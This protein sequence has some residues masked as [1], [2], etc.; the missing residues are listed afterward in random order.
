MFVTLDDFLNSNHADNPNEGQLIMNPDTHQV[1]YK[2]NSATRKVTNF[3][4]WLEAYLNY[5]KLMIKA[6]GIMA[7]HAMSDYI[8][9]IHKNDARF[10]WYAVDNFDVQHRQWLSGKTINMLNVDPIIVAANLVSAAAKYEA[11]CTRCRSPDHTTAECPLVVAVPPSGRR[12]RSSS[13]GK[14]NEQICKKYNKSNCTFQGC[15][16]SHKCIVC[17]GDLPI[18][19]CLIR[20]PCAEKDTA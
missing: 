1:T 4:T 16:R 17:K 18:K 2:P 5:M 19:E 14:R 20:G 13:R 10:Y 8:T 7:Y 3:D 11:R 9:F 12:N 6:N 15:K